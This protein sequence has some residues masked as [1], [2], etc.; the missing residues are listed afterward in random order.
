[1]SE[2]DLVNAIIQYITVIGGVATRLNSGMKVVTD[3]DSGK[4]Y[5]F[6]GSKK[7]TSDIIGCLPPNGRYLAIEVKDG[8][9]KRKNTTPEQLEYIDHVNAAGGIAFIACDID[10]VVRRLDA[11]SRH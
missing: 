10:D 8:E 9:K 11:Y 1:M 2:Q 4:Q 7:G 3:P 5:V 6:R